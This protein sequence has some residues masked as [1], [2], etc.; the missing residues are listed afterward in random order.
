MDEKKTKN[1][2]NANKNSGKQS[3]GAAKATIIGAVIITLI[4]VLGNLWLLYGAQR[5]TEKAVHTVSRLYLDELAGRREQVVESNLKGRISDIQVAL[6]LMT[7]KDLSDKAHLEAYQKRIKKTHNLERFAFVDQDGLIYTSTGTQK[8]IDEYPFDPK[9]IAKPEISIFDLNNKH[10]KVII[11]VPVSIR[12]QDNTFSCCFMQI[13]ME[14]MLSGVSMDPQAK[15]TTFCNM[16]TRDGV[17]LTDKV[18]GGLA[19]EDNLLKAMKNARFRRL[20]IQK[21]PGRIQT[22]YQRTGFLHL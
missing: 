17:A 3:K 20:F 14:K 12:F 13:A 21:I 9:K 7:D 15:G 11:A 18:L 4:L 6:E 19:V 16:Y 10:K 1:I 2:I 8:N 22:G 5:D